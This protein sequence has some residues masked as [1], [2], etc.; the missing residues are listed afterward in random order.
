MKKLLCV[1][2]FGM[3]FGQDAIT[4]REYRIDITNETNEIN[5]MELIGEN[6]GYYQVVPLVIEDF[7]FNSTYDPQ[8]CS[9]FD[10]EIETCGI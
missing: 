1:L 2:M 7:I 4:T 9:G 8:N 10:S 5:L 3:M 6:E